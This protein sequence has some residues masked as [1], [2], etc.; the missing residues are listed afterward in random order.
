MKD[1]KD[2]LRQE[3]GTETQSC[4][5]PQPWRDDPRVG[6]IL[7]IWSMSLRNEEFEPHIRHLNHWG[8][9]QRKEPPRY[10]ALKTNG[11]YEQETQKAIENRY[12]TDKGLIHRLA[13]PRS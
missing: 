8:L 1:E 3:G 10:L 6:G 2:T 11:A 5:K 13:H 7:Q 4:H 9:P 12:S